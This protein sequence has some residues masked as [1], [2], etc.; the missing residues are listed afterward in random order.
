[1]EAA[2]P[3]INGMVALNLKNNRPSRCC[4]LHGV[5]WLGFLKLG[6]RHVEQNTMVTVINFSE[7]DARVG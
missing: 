3:T 7:N 2:E 4:T 1:M 5:V 6:R